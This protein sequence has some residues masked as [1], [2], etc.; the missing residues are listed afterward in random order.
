MLYISTDYVFDGKNAPYKESDTPN[1]LNTYGK[2]KLAG[3]NVVLS[4]SDRMLLY[5]AIDSC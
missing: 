2:T 5:L 4:S 1:P 3:E